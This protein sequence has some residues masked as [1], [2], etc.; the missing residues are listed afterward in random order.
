MITGYKTII[1][2][3]YQ[4]ILIQIGQASSL[5]QWAIGDITLAIIQAHDDQK[6][7]VPVMSIYAAISVFT[8]K[9]SRSIRSYAHISITW[10]KAI[11][12]RFPM[13]SFDHYRQAQAFGRENG[14]KA[15]EWATNQAEELGGRPATVD[16]M[17]AWWLTGGATHSETIIQS[18]EEPAAVTAAR[19]G[20]FRKSIM[21]LKN[22]LPI[23][24]GL[25]VS[26]NSIYQLTECLVRIE[27][28]IAQALYEKRNPL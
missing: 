21:E 6:T 19:I 22:W 28:E 4:D 5:A 13:L 1:P 3:E 12:D 15:L 18:G 10:E 9:S 17:L 24:K 23:I 7:N 8:G 11:R 2:D 25:N 14:I 20:A 27:D 26:D 16:A